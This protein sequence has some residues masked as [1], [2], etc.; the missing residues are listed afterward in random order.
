MWR[1]LE[2]FLYDWWPIRTEVRLL[3]RLSRMPVRIEYSPTAPADAWRSDWPE[4][5]A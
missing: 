3:Q 5:K 1:P 4:V 2:V